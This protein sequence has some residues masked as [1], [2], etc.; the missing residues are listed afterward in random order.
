[1]DEEVRPDLIW[2]LAFIMNGAQ[3]LGRCTVVAHGGAM[4][5]GGG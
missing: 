2:T 3:R 4:A 1:M 5:D